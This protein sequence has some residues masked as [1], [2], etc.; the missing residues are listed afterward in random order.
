M[1]AALSI[2]WQQR[3]LEA[4]VNRNS[5]QYY[6][7]TCISNISHTYIGA[8]KLLMDDGCSLELCVATF[9]VASSGIAKHK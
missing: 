4:I 6:S 2:Q 1:A 9:S 3:E 5:F 7:Y 8:C